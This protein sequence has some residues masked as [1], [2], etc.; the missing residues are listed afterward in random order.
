MEPFAE[1][2]EIV[3]E[4]M[5]HGAA[6]HPD[7]DWLRRTPEYHISRAIEHLRL[8]QEGGQSQDYVSH[9]CCRLL[10]ALTLRE[11]G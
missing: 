10:M 7:N 3:A 9:A 5:R 11:L 4:V 8:W 1:A 2:L 6:S